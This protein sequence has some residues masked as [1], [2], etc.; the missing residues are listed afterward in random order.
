MIKAFKF[1]VL[2]LGVTANAL[3]TDYQEPPPILTSPTE[4]TGSYENSRVGKISAAFT[5]SEGNQDS[6]NIYRLDLVGTT[7]ERG[8]AYGAMM[9]KEIVRF[10]DV[11]LNKYYMDMVLDIDLSGF[12]EPLQKILHVIQVK[13]ALAAPEAFNKAMQWVYEQEEQYMPEYLLEEMDAIGAGVCHTLGGSCNTTEMAATVRR[14]NMLPELIRMACTMFGAW[15]PASPTGKLTQIRALDFGSGPFSNYTILGVYRSTEA[16][17]RAFA[18]VMYPGMV[19]AITGVAQ[20][21]IGIS[22]KVWMTYDCNPSCLQPGHYDGEPDVFVLRDILQQAKNRQEAETYMQNAKRTFAIFVGVGDFESQT[23]DVVGYKED[24]A[25]VYTDQTISEVTEMKVLDSVVYVDKH[26]QPSTDD[27]LPTAL[28]DF[29]GELSMENSRVVVQ[30]HKTGDQHI[31]M[32]D[33]GASS[34][35]LSVGRINKDGDYGPEGG[36]L[37]QWKAYNRPYLKFDLEDLWA[38]L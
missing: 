17:T 16:D 25:T 9:A 20:N 1:A 36:D 24:S 23:M 13:G 21:G 31:A 27:S 29:Y 2:A 35:L 15:G 18:T 30:Y 37:S 4:W 3:K 22:E 6:V 5:D 12:P 33:F 14:L 38:G 11:A 34:M 28:T 19:G 10:I 8:F 26:P 32:Y 7:K